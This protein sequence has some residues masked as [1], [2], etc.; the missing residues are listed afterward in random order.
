MHSIEP[1]YFWQDYYIASEDKR[2]PFYGRTYNEFYFT[3]TIYNYYIHPQW[4]PFGSNT[5][6]GKILYCNYDAK[7]VV[8]ELIGE[9]N[10]CLYNDV[11]FLYENIILPLIGQGV[12]QFIVIGENVLNFHGSENDYYGAWYEEICLNKGWI[13]FLNTLEH[14]EIEMREYRIHDYVHFINDIHWRK[15]HPEKLITVLSEEI[16]EQIREL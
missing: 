1:F 10:D 8:I 5:L 3:N 16:K 6:Y 15:L 13:V 9:W 2:S 12:D 7:F 4:D 11:M 14:V